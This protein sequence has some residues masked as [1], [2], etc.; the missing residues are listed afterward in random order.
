M[1]LLWLC[2]IIY[3]WPKKDL[4]QEHQQIKKMKEGVSC[5]GYIAKKKYN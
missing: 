4:V 5:N 3:A 1:F 2:N